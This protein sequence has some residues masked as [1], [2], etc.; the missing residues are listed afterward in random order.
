MEVFV[1]MLLGSWRSIDEV[2]N[3]LIDLGEM[4]CFLQLRR[5]MFSEENISY[6]SSL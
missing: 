6:C 5:G 2:I 1:S 3:F 4:E